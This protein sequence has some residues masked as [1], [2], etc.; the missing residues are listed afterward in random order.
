[1][2]FEFFLFDFIFYFFYEQGR[3]MQLLKLFV[4]FWSSENI[5]DLF[6]C[7]FLELLP[8]FLSFF[9]ALLKSTMYLSSI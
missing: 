7:F 5:L 2:F 8:C 6:G 9:S 1:M 4:L 3:Y